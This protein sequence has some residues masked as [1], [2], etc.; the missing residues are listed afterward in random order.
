LESLLVSPQLVGIAFAEC[1]EDID[2][3]PPLKSRLT[4]PQ[5][6]GIVQV[7]LGDIHSMKM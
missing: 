3:R 4:S 6:V 1:L 7:E 5:S 2:R